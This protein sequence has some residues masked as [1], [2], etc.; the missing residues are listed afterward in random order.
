MKHYIITRFA[1]WLSAGSGMTIEKLFSDEF[2]NDSFIK[3]KNALIPTLENQTNKNFTLIINIHND[4]PIEKLFFLK[5]LNTTFEIKIL[6]TNEISTFI[7]KNSIGNDNVIISRIDIDDFIR[8]DII[9]LIQ[10]YAVT[11]KE[12]YIG[13]GLYNGS[14]LWYEDKTVCAVPIQSYI[15]NNN[16]PFSCMATIIFN[17]N[18][19]KL[20][21][22]YYLNKGPVGY[23]HTKMFDFIKNFIDKFDKNAKYST[24]FI[25]SENE[26]KPLYL[27]TGYG[28]N[29]T[30]NYRKLQNKNRSWHLSDNKLNIS[31]KEYGLKF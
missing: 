7:L 15:K 18:K 20:W 19:S 9:D 6:R 16:G 17:N 10:K 13:L 24:F 25:K 3:L 8:N 31:F 11:T 29:I 27:W 26:N 4:I 28:N 21:L 5:E 30:I 1:S 22:Q 12:D 23:N 2:L 14:T